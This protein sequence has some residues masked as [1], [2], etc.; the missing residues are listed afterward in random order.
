MHNQRLHSFFSSSLCVLLCAALSL[1]CCIF[2]P[3][4]SILFFFCRLPLFLLS[5]AT[6]RK[7]LCTTD[8]YITLCVC[9]SV[10]MSVV[11]QDGWQGRQ[12]EGGVNKYGK[13]GLTFTCI[14][15]SRPVYCVCWCFLSLSSFPP[16]IIPLPPF[17][18]SFPPSLHTELLGCEM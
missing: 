14:Y 1:F 4:L 15:S 5:A 7:Q 17:P 10:C 13:K 8:N 12:K 16:L 3:F 2:P 11:T 6:M 18:P 9:V